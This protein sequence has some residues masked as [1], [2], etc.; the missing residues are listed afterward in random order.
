MAGQCVLCRPGRSR[1]CVNRWRTDLRS[2]AV[3]MGCAD[4]GCLV[5]DGIR[6]I[7]C[8]TAECCCTDL[9]IAA[10]MDV[11]AARIRTAFNARDMDTFRALIAVDAKWGDDTDHPRSCHS[12]DDIIRT[13]KRNLAEGVRGVVTETETGPR[14]VMCVVEVEWPDPD[15]ENRPQVFQA[16]YVND[17]LVTRIEGHEDRESALTAISS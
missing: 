13:Y 10:P 16:F 7:P 15:P 6:I 1:I 17:G 5:A 3:E 8:D 12:R 2:V 11:M 14:G 9:P 4:C